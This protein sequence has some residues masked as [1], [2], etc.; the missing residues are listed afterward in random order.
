MGQTR[1][2]RILHIED[3]GVFSLAGRQQTPLNQVPETLFHIENLTIRPGDRLALLG[4]NGT[5]K[6]SLIQTIISSYN[7]DINGITDPAMAKVLLE[8]IK[9]SPQCRIGYYDQELINLKPASTLLETLR[10]HCGVTDAQIVSALIRAGFPYGDHDKKISML[11]GGEKARIVFLT[12]QINQPNFLI[13]DEPTNHIDIQGKEELET[14][15]LESQAT[16]LITSHDRRFINTIAN[17]YVLI[18]NGQLHEIHHPDDF[19]SAQTFAQGEES[20]NGRHG[21]EGETPTLPSETVLSDD[22]NPDEL[23]ERL[24][25]LEEKLESDRQRR[26]KHQKPERQAEWMAEIRTINQ[27]LD[28]L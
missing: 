14:Q 18:R 15:L 6:T 25:E 21:S 22:L 20:R 23:L 1:A 3:F 26:A 19:W 7:E 8:K 11:S 4:E 16:L 12:L 9:I 28:K 24:I 10:E 13:L 27:H 2:N 17:R 5:G